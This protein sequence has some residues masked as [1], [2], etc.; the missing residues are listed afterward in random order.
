[1]TNPTAWARGY[2]VGEPYPAAWH[3][4]Q[5]PAHLRAICALMGVAWDVGPDTPLSIAEVGCGTGYTAAMLAAGNPRWKVLGLD[6]N[7]AHIAAARS[8]ADA[9]AI[10]NLSFLEADL[11]EL[12]DADIDRLPEFDL[13][14][15]HGV[16]SWVADSVREGVLRLLRR[17]LKTG[18][19]A[20]V[21]YNAMPGAAG[22]Q[23]LARVVRGAL[24]TAS[25][26]DGGL[27]AA[28]KLVERLVAA[29]ATHL[30]P[31]GWRRMF[32]GEETRA[33]PGYLLH[34][35]LTEHWR[36]A[37][38]ADVSASL[39]TARCQY[40][41]SATID[42]N[43]PEMS[44]TPAQREIWEEAPDEAARQLI[45]DLCVRRAFRRDLY[46]RGLRRLPRDAAVE[47]L[48]VASASHA[49][50]EVS[51]QTQAGAA[52]LPQPL[53]DA[54]RERLRQG[55]QS[56]AA[57]RALP[58]C[59][60]VTPSE[61][62]ALLIDTEIAVP[63]WRQPGSGAG[64]A[65]SVAAARRLNAVAADRLAMYGAGSGS[66]GLAAAPLGGGLAASALEL[67]VA[68]AV[69]DAASDGASGATA[70]QPKAADIVDRILPPGPRPAAETVADLEQMVTAVLRVRLPVW[71]AL[72]IV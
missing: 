69:S 50:G 41:G 42:E 46:V 7:P 62:I 43:F 22:S 11:A 16:W 12:S 66:F 71:R 59:G 10:E 2:P 25:G 17:R 68:R 28:A 63:L 15:V 27:A 26:S 1:M 45:M 44:L 70:G 56:I 61:L 39:A 67:A 47:A 19:L 31:S 64:W 54:V 21:T 57:L 55:P 58:G 9:A 65:Q 72:A 8:M 30:P 53:I 13:V 48:W 4:F 14:T 60:K 38:F 36:P 5:S 37:F 49:E 34:E 3:W 51:M 35:F 33:R 20:L 29:E 23:G 18:G 32:T 24:V 52:T 6:Y 40:V